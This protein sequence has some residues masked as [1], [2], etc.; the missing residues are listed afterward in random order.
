MNTQRNYFWL[1]AGIINLITALV[2]TFVGQIELINPL[3]ISNLTTQKKAEWFSVWHIVTILLFASAYFIL[4]NAFATF[5]QRQPELMRYV[6]ILYIAFSI[7]F[8]ISSFM[9]QLLVPQ[10]ILLLPI[11]LLIYFGAKKTELYL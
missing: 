11:G 10:W 8:I 4:K 1:I 7:P 3:L 9:Y 6:G 5:E 2:H